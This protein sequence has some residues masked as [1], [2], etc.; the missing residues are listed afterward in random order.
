MDGGTARRY[1]STYTGQHN[2]ERDGRD[3]NTRYQ[4]SEV[5]ECRHHTSHIS[6]SPSHLNILR[7]NSSLS[8]KQSMGT[9]LRYDEFKNVFFCTQQTN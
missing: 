3:S 8:S 5:H 4:E 1:V 9:D 7:F 6:M 2:T